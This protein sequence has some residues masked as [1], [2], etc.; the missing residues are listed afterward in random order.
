MALKISVQFRVRDPTGNINQPRISRRV[1]RAEM[2]VRRKVM[3]RRAGQSTP[4][5]QLLGAILRYP[6]AGG[7]GDEKGFCKGFVEQGKTDCESYD[8]SSGEEVT[9][10]TMKRTRRRKKGMSQ[11]LP[12][13]IDP[14]VHFQPG[15]VEAASASASLSLSSPSPP[16]ARH[17]AANAI[18]A[19]DKYLN[20]NSNRRQIR[21]HGLRRLPLF[22]SAFDGR[23]DDRT[24]GLEGYIHRVGIR[25]LVAAARPPR[26][27]AHLG[28][29]PFLYLPL[30]LPPPPANPTNFHPSIPWLRYSPPPARPPSASTSPPVSPGCYNGATRSPPHPRGSPSPLPASRLRLRWREYL[31]TIHCF[32]GLIECASGAHLRLRAASA[33]Y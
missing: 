14:V 25:I 18:A 27:H 12:P 22:L 1:R 33:S 17:M 9:N 28:P 16:L 26:V 11:D 29:P 15:V 4:I 2:D 6:G 23:K 13:R 19:S 32:D 5:C 21:V 24:A 8:A 10:R 20:A 30:H 31:L 7:R 3:R